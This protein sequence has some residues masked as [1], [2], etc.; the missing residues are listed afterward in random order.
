M[1]GLVDFSI[2]Y[3][4]ANSSRMLNYNMHYLCSNSRTTHQGGD[5]FR[6]DSSKQNGLLK[7]AAPPHDCLGSFLFVGQ[8]ADVPASQGG[9]L[10]PQESFMQKA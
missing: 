1:A 6:K 5:S 4:F 9:S 8:R 10:T 2:T 7:P 3:G